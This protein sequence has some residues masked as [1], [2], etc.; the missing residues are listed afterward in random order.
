M[1]STE[2]KPLQCAI[3][4]PVAIVGEVKHVWPRL[5]SSRLCGSVGCDWC[6]FAGG[7]VTVVCAGR[8]SEK[9]II[10]NGSALLAA[11]LPCWLSFTAITVADRNRGLVFNIVFPCLHILEKV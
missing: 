9:T 11:A 1:T 4:L 10:E 5:A 8:Q 3:T 6:D 7:S 2:K